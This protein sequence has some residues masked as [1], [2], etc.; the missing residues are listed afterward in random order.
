MTC[1]SSILIERA[2]KHLRSLSRDIDKEIAA[3]GSP[4]A[5]RIEATRDAALKEREVLLRGLSS[6]REQIEVAEGEK[7]S[8]DQRLS[9]LAAVAER[10][11]R[12]AELG[13]E[14]RTVNENIVRCDVEL[15][16]ACRGAVAEP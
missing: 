10:A 9:N 2:S 12:R 1:F 13:S 16:D 14:L 5:K 11:K 7:Q 6:L 4:E 15:M 8:I 3:K